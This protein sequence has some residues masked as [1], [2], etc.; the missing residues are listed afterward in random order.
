MNLTA[1]QA[2]STKYL[3]ATDHRGVRIKAT[4]CAGTLTVPYDYALNTANNHAAAGVALAQRLGWTGT[5][6]IG[7][8]KDGYVLVF[9][10]DYSTTTLQGA[11][12]G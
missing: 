2:I 11:T 6:S 12:M 7:G 8:T 3:G 9:V 4:C 10:D 5:L 1:C